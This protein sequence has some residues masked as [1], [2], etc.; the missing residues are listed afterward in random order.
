MFET[1][2]KILNRATKLFKTQEKIEV[3]AF[4]LRIG[5]A[6]A[7]LLLHRS[8]SYS[9]N[10]RVM[11]MNEFYSFKWKKLNREV[12]IDPSQEPNPHV[13]ITGMSGFGKSTLFKSMLLDINEH[14]IPAIIFDAHD[15]HA[16]MVRHLSGQVYDAEYSGINILE[17]DGASVAER[18]SELT[19]LFKS[20]YSLGYIQATKL[21]SCLWYT[22]RK[23]GAR[24]KTDRHIPKAPTIKDLVAELNIFIANAK[25]VAERNTLHHLQDRM[26]L[27]NTAA[28]GSES[29]GIRDLQNGIHLFSLA[30]MRSTE[31]QLIYIGELLSRLYIQ[32]KENT[33]ESGIRCYVMIDEAQFLMDESSGSNAIIGRLIEEGRKYGLGVIIVSHAAS[34]LNRQIVANASTFITFYAREPNEASYSSKVLSGGDNGRAEA[35]RSRLRALRQNEAMIVS[36]SMRDPI[37]VSTPRYDSLPQIEAKPVQNEAQVLADASRPIHEND[38]AKRLSSDKID[39]LVAE[40]RLEKFTVKGDDGEDTFYMRHKSS[41]SIEHEACVAKISELLTKNHMSNTIIDNSNGPDVVAYLNGKKIAIEYET[42]KKTIK[43]TIKMLELREKEYS[44]TIVVVNDSAFKFYQDSIPNRNIVLL[45]ASRLSVI[46]E[47]LTVT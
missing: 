43:S 39:A 33:K 10:G 15:E 23:M 32:M 47:I 22:Y 28:F 5:N 8:V 12:K 40:N 44:K 7:M 25:T 21:S 37:I 14:K 9:S 20:V 42:G 29:L 4:S 6:V 46:I 2:T 41:L 35:I 34:T 45:P 3:Y 16:A 1:I 30:N 26:S 18:I 36:G 19:R 24:S 13:L 27:L 38:I 31:A 11:R 17:L